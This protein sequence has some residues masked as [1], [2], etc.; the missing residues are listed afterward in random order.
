MFDVLLI[1][2]WEYKARSC[3]FR[4]QLFIRSN[5]HLGHRVSFIFDRRDY[6]LMSNDVK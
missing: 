2:H 6:D 1:G 5:N 3:S 4:K